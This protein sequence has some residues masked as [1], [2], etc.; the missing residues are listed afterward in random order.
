MPLGERWKMNERA[1]IVKFPKMNLT[2]KWNLL[3]KFRRLFYSVFSSSHSTNPTSWRFRMWEIIFIPTLDKVLQ[4]FWALLFSHTRA[5]FLPCVCVRV[6]ASVSS[7][8]YFILVMNF[9][10]VQ[11]HVEFYVTLILHF[12]SNKPHRHPQSTT[13][14]HKSAAIRP[15]IW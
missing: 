12:S 8:T 13:S 7:V 6:Y 9:A 11:T 4:D 14:C 3:E 2:L 1:D 10:S 5:A 15:S